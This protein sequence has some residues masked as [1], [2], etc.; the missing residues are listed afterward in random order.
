MSLRARLTASEIVIAPGVY[1]GLTATLA[2]QAGFEALYLSGA[3]VAYTRL[4]RP[5]IGLT[6]VSEMADTMALIRDRTALPVIIDADTGFGN[7]LNAQRTMRLYERA[8]ASALQ[9]ED[10]TYPKRCG[11]LADKSLISAAE[12]AGKIAA[13]ADARASDATLII[14]RTDAIAVE[15]FDAAME[16]AEAYVAAGAD[17]LFIEAPRTGDELA[18]VARTFR[19][20]VPLLANMVEG[21]HTPITSATDLQALGFDIV[22]FPGGIVRALAR[23][24]QDYYASLRAHG[25]NTPFADR[26]FDFDG[27]N[28]RIGTAEMLAMGQRFDGQDKG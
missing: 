23:T 7:A 8:G 24:A 9:V 18:Q 19:G 12:M 14:A 10:Q 11:H 6:S 16:R 28:A 1:D 20:R 27:L 26:M 4:G 3:A 2:E 21:G 15:G 17:V 5:D 22:I 25:S 13:M